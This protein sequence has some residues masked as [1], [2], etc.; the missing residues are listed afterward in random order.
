MT[1]TTPQLSRSALITV[2]TQSDFVLP[3]AVAEIPGSMAIIGNMTTLLKTNRRNHLPIVH[4]VRLY[5]SDGANAD[6]CRRQ[7]LESGTALV[8]PNSQG[9]ELVAD[10]KPGAHA[11]LDSNLLLSG[12]VQSW[13]HREV[14]VYKPRWGGFYQTPLDRHLRTMGITTLVVSGCNFPN[15]P[16][17]TIYEASERDYRLVVVTD[18]ISGIYPQAMEELG[19]IGVTLW[20]TEQL[21]AK[22]GDGD[23]LQHPRSNGSIS[24]EKNGL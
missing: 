10:L 19:N 17:A 23:S 1:Y 18:A 11:R 13:G 7:L 22:L 24:N 14:V 8:H 12:K 5:L 2:D 16:R 15:C 6:I 21:V 4:L 3:G 20:S 9:A